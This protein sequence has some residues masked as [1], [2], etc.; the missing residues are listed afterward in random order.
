[1]RICNPCKHRAACVRR[2]CGPAWCL[3]KAATALDHLARLPVVVLPGPML[4]ARIQ[5]VSV[6]D[7]AAAI[8]ALLGPALATEG[9]IECV[10]PEAL[11]LSDFVAS[12]RQ[13][14]GHRPA[15]R[16]RLPDAITRL[17]ARL[18]DAVPASPWCTDTLT[19]L[20]SNNT[21]DPA[22]FAQLLGRSPVHYSQLVATAWR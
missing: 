14:Q 8:T 21:G 10:G 5:P 18:G 13:Q 16:L 1:M 17:S 22:P 7:L 11:P 9:I 3:A 4:T 6:H 12:L 2:S 15:H 19:M 20:G